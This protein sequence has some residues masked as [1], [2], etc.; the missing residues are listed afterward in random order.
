MG[1]FWV[2][3]YAGY[4]DGVF[5]MREVLALALVWALLLAS[6]LITGVSEWYFYVPATGLTI[7]LIVSVLGW[8]APAGGASA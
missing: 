8:D 3:L 7:F 2:L 1:M 4:Q 5:S 6:V